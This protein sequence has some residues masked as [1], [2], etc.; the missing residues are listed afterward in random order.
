M[1]SARHYSHQVLASLPFNS[2]TAL[3]APMGKR[4]TRPFVSSATLAAHSRQARDTSH[5]TSSTRLSTGML[6]PE[7]HQ[8]G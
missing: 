3:A 6:I 2:R 8:D 5:S 7:S 4:R 1:S